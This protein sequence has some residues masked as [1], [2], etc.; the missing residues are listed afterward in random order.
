MYWQAWIRWMLSLRSLL[1]RWMLRY[2]QEEPVSGR[3]RSGIQ[4]LMC[5]VDVRQ[6]AIEVALSVVSGAYQTSLLSYFTHRDLF[7]SLMKV[8]TQPS[9]SKGAADLESLYKILIPLR[10]HLSLSRFSV[11]SPITTN[12]NFRTHTGYGLMTS[13]MRER[14]KR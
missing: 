7:P 6:K 12:S 11:F 8:S 5:T 14:S 4:M 2:V 10:A 3:N 13:S 9:R 1:R